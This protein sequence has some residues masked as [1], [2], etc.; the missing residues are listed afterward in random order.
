MSKIANIKHT[1][2]DQSVI[3]VKYDNIKLNIED[4]I[5]INTLRG[6]ELAQVMKLDIKLEDGTV[7][8]KDTTIERV[9]T[10]KDIDKGKANKKRASAILKQAKELVDKLS[11]DMRLVD[12]CLTLDAQKVVINFVCD[13]RVDFREFVKQLASSLK[14]KIELKQI[15]A[16]DKAKSVG[17]I[18]ACGQECCCIR[19]KSDFDKVSIKM[20]KTQ[21]LSLN[22]SNISGVCGRLMCCLAYENDQ[23]TTAVKK[24]PKVNSKV[25]TPDG[26]GV[27]IFNNLLKEMVTVKLLAEDKKIQVYS[28]N[29]VEFKSV[30]G[31]P[32]KNQAQK[33]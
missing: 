7:V 15:G 17:G 29:D 33:A 24:M 30:G 4:T 3:N 16:R 6:K 8:D 14:M 19:Y 5:V 12:A 25:K 21:N 2:G 9:A 18:G 26:E 1:C 13:N 27:V 31:C 23:Y 20:A 22:P 32:M 11:L 10:A 28:L